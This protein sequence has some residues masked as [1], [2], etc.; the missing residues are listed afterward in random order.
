MLNIWDEDEEKLNRI[1]VEDL[2][3][4]KMLAKKGFKIQNR[5]IQVNEWNNYTRIPKKT[6][7]IIAN[8]KIIKNDENAVKFISEKIKSENFSH[9]FRKHLNMVRREKEMAKIKK[10]HWKTFNSEQKIYGKL[11]PPPPKDQNSDDFPYKFFNKENLQQ[12]YKK[13][14]VKQELFEKLSVPKE[15]F[16]FF[17]FL[18]FFSNFIYFFIKP[19]KEPENNPLDYKEFRGL[20]IG[21]VDERTATQ[22]ENELIKKL[23]K[24]E[25]LRQNIEKIRKS[26]PQSTQSKRPV[27]A[28]SVF[29]MNYDVMPEQKLRELEIL[30][31]TF[32][33]FNHEKLFEDREVLKSKK[34]KNISLKN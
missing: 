17:N 3:I 11:L 10:N 16:F 30:T 14:L 33:D 18:F 2:E 28:K 29:G 27:T 8:D 5:D 4:K 24:S 21:D 12:F 22:I 7:D 32:S 20:F 34:F 31:K 1:S 6:V 23:T 9:E 26:R 15:V 19:I 13:K 25:T